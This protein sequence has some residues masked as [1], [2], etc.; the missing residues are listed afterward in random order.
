MDKAQL[1]QQFLARRRSLPLTEWQQLSY[2]VCHQLRCLPQFQ[3]ANTIAAYFTTQ[4]E[5]DLSPLFTPAKTWGFPRCVGQQLQWSTW[6][7]GQPLL[8]GKYGIPM[9][10]LEAPLLDPAHIDLLLI[11]AVAG[12]RQGYRLGY[13]G[14]F[15]DRLLANLCLAT[16]ASPGH[17]FFLCDGG[18]IIP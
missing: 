2:Q 18:G 6:Q 4:Q 9:P 10:P 7:P 3:Q 12:D 15:Y 14:G 5:P 1:R 13:G 11:P 17:C 16:T 8:P